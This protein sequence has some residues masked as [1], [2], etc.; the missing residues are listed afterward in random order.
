MKPLHIIY[1][2]ILLFASCAM[3]G[4]SDN[5]HVNT[6][7]EIENRIGN[8]PKVAVRYVDS[9]NADIGWKEGMNA[10]ERA[11]FDLLRVKSAD[12]AY[13][14]H[15]SDSLIRSVLGYYEKHTRSEQYPEAL[16]YGGRVYSDLGDSPIALRYFQQALDALSGEADQRLRSTV[17]SQTARLMN[18]MRMY[19]QAQ[20]YL[21]EVIA[22]NE[23]SRDSAC[24]AYD[25]ELSGAIYMHTD[26]LDQARILFDKALAL[27]EPGSGMEARQYTYLA[28][29]QY[30]RGNFKDAARLISG[31]PG[32][33]SGTYRTT[34]MGYAAQIY[35]ETGQYD[36]AIY[37]AD[38]ILKE[39]DTR[40]HRIAYG[41][42]LSPRLRRLLPPDSVGSYYLRYG[43]E[44]AEFAD[45]N[46]RE[47]CAFNNAI[48]NYGI[49]DRRRQQ[50][51]DDKKTY[52][53]AGLCLLLAVLGLCLTVTVIRQ[54]N[55][56]NKLDLYEALENI[57]TLRSLLVSAHSE[58]EAENNG[59]E[60]ECKPVTDNDENQNEDTTP[61][62]TTDSEFLSDDEKSC[63]DV[64][65]VC[66]DVETEDERLRLILRKE[67]LGLITVSSK[68][69][70]PSKNYI[71]PERI[72]KSEAY[73][74]VCRSLETGKALPPDATIWQDLKKLAR[75]VWPGLQDKL[76]MLAGSRIKE[77][78]YRL[79]LLIKLGFSPTD[80]TVLSGRTKG[81]I[82]SR[83]A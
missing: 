56:R 18:R 59:M 28:A 65:S 38:K 68:Y 6:F 29:I 15:T 58:K 70:R 44:I 77:K 63:L 7:N 8:D 80:I 40:N 72:A 50:A 22:I 36:S 26:S 53:I 41:V 32:R 55:N 33:I 48:Y 75:E 79:C 19:D 62:N 2:F 10:A 37:Y 51:E 78:D 11:R 24:L 1:I 67:L 47:A 31:M 25:Y 14:R 71:V 30:E 34:S 4:C 57:R 27:S 73:K 20:T 17:L 69:T 60:T 81:T 3:S 23:Q 64:T 21:K 9:L 66:A 83:R 5:E 43:E 54:R 35:L 39:K 52:A 12:K 46:N 13:V 16:Y 49:H 61:D 76:N 45:N 82:S 74:D 42:L